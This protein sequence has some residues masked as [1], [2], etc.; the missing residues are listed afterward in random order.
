METPGMERRPERRSVPRTITPLSTPAADANA[1][2]RFPFKPAEL[3]K[4]VRA[5]LEEDQAFNDVTTIATIVSDRRARATL[6]ARGNGTIAGVALALEAFRT[7]DPKG[8]IRVDRE[9]GFRVQKG[10]PIL[11]VT[12]HARGLLGAERVALNFMQ[13]M[14]GIASLTAK[15]VAAVAG[16]KAKILDTRKT[17]PG[18]RQ[19]EKYSVRAG[20]GLNHRMDLA[21][22]VLIKDNHLA[23]CDGDVALAVKRAR[24]MAP[25]GTK[26][27]VECESAEHVTA[28]VNAGAHI[29]LL[30]N[31]PLELMRECVALASGRAKVE[32][33][34]GVNLQTVRGIA[35]TGVDWISVG[36]LTH[37]PPALDLALDFD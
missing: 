8:T 29:V 19:L 16:T 30:D 32:A 27:E 25:D 20:G 35:E 17:T 15:F 13:R 3:T 21:E 26:I 33:S 10:D 23:A 37:S 14:S 11:F 9:D 24:D 2:L 5:A 22:A 34:G 1:L 6:V 31:M 36:A 28:A 4:L 7:M 12:G 18:W